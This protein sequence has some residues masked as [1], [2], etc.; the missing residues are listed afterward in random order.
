MLKSHTCVFLALVATLFVPAFPIFAELSLDS[1]VKIHRQSALDLGAKINHGRLVGTSIE[2]RRS[3]PRSEAEIEARIAELTGTVKNSY[4]DPNDPRLTTHLKAIPYI[5]KYN[6]TND[7]TVHKR[8][9]LAMSEGKM[10]CTVEWLDRTDSYEV[11]AWLKGTNFDPSVTVENNTEYVT[12]WDGSVMTDYSAP[13]HW[14]E[15]TKDKR[16][17]LGIFQVGDTVLQMPKFSLANC[18]M[19]PL[20]EDG[21][22]SIAI[23]KTWMLPGRTQNDTIPELERVDTIVL[24][25]EKE[26]VPLSTLTTLPDGFSATEFGG[27]EKIASVKGD[28]WFPRFAVLIN[29]KMGDDGILDIERDFLYRCT[30]RFEDVD[31]TSPIGAEQFELT[32]P[33]GTYVMDVVRGINYAVKKKTGSLDDLLEEA[34]EELSLSES[35]KLAPTPTTA[36]TEQEETPQQKTNAQPESHAHSRSRLK[37][38][39]YSSVTIAACLALFYRWLK[40]GK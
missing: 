31:L 28:C 19:E 26:F 24:D 16:E 11:P 37:V 4:T 38:A 7:Y 35:P 8:F 21:K 15:I 18:S 29:G 12:L 5:V 36:S 6:L 20:S 14:A 10:I 9:S 3:P 30:F 23:T 32:F 34:G 40:A 22:E 27:Y 33:E 39:L 13:G 25:P 2:E 1:V 17:T